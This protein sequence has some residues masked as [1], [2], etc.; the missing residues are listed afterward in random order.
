MQ[1]RP[2]PSLKRFAIVGCGRIAERHAEHIAKNGILT[3]VCDALPAAADRFCTS[4]PGVKPFASIKE[5]LA[6]DDGNV[7]DVI[8]ICSPNKFHAAHS[9]AA[10]K[11]GYHVLCEKPMAINVHDCGEMIKAAERA[12]R[13]LFIVKQ[14][15]FNPPV[16][17]VKALIDSGRFG[18]ILSF[19][20]S[21]FWNRNA[22][23]YADSWRG[24]KEVD[25]GSLYTLFSHFID[26]L[27]WMVGDVSEVLAVTGNLAHAGVIEIEDTGAVVLRCHNG[28]MGTLNYTVNSYGGNM[29][30]SIT[31]FG[32][33]GTAK[34]GG[35]YL[36]EL[37]YLKIEGDD[38]LE[39]TTA[40]G[41]AKYDGSQSRIG[42]VY[43]NVVEVLDGRGI[44][45]ANGFEGLK[46]VEII[47]RIYRS[48]SPQSGHV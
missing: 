17:Q 32:D 47:D 2:I 5:M 39:E 11:A 28:A 12:N 38:G 46:T 23:Y 19:Q 15:R 9:I 10:L 45:A 6:A 33:K 37:E 36:N 14:N 1:P 25:G 27:Y 3:A 43:Q 29:E 31:L 30:G 20:I 42:E 8:S 35:Q 16:A 48:A 7:A 44:I 13:R 22:Q 18:K 34:I 21:C 40:K 26:L 4:R 41:Y 24:T